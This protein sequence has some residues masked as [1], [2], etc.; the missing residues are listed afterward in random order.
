M[1]GFTSTTFRQLNVDQVIDLALKSKSECIEWGGDIHIKTLDQA[2]EVKS[3]C[4]NAG[5]VI[6]SYGSYYRVGSGNAEEWKR[7]CEIAAAMGARTI[8]VWL[9]TVGSRLTGNKRYKKMLKDGKHM[10]EIASEYGLII[11]SECHANTY[12]DSLASSLKFLQDIKVDNFKTYYQS[13]YQHKAEDLQRLVKTISFVE[14][15]HL[16]FSELE[17]MQLLRK[18][19]NSFIPEI[20]KILKESCFKGNI[21]LEY[22]RGAERDNFIQDIAR[23]RELLK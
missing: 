17:R 1:L 5:I 8:R 18:K 11:A 2:I 15:V 4:N 20:I 19:D 16:S 13:R 14:N 10:S 23:L 6:S 22:V 7:I 21:L 3:K 9:G 12:N